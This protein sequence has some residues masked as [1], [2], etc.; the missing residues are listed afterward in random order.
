MTPSC[1]LHL[2]EIDIGNLG[3]DQP[4]SHPSNDS[5]AGAPQVDG[6]LICYD[7]TSQSSFV[8]VEDLLSESDTFISM[9]LLN[10]THR[11]RTSTSLKTPVH[12]LGMQVG[13]GAGG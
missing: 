1:P 13:P 5:S 8:H 12:G 10:G 9:E 2:L 4:T 11:L 7:A 3:W 6:V